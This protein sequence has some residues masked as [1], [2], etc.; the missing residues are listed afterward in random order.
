MN[1]VTIFKGLDADELELLKP[2]FEVFSCQS[3][4]FIFQQGE[5]ADFLYLLIEGKVEMSFKPYDE[6]PI[7][8]A[9]VEK[10]DLF[11]W[12][13]VVGSDKY[14]SSAMATENVV[15]YRVHGGELHKFC[16]DHPNA[17][18]DILERL[19]DC[20]SF[21]QTD[22]HRQVQSMILQGMKEKD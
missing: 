21:R 3:G 11:G 7:T 18:Q 10:D 15:A 16:R 17:G 5:P 6:V 2:L 19:A 22:A 4:T 20:V 8:I 12:S 13:A 14:T 9:Q 1:R